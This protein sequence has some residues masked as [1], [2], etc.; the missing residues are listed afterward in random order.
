MQV[1]TLYLSSA[2]FN[3]TVSPDNNVH[4]LRAGCMTGNGMV[5]SYSCQSHPLAAVGTN[6]M[7]FSFS[8]VFVD[9]LSAQPKLGPL[10]ISQVRLM[11][12]EL[13]PV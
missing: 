7:K 6:V 2:I 5:H 12:Q 13:P 3:L 1:Q 10:V 8:R 11:L 4:F 9:I